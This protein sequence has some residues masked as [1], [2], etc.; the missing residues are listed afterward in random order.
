VYFGTSRSANRIAVDTDSGGSSPG[1][2]SRVFSTSAKDTSH[3][4]I[5]PSVVAPYR[6]DPSPIVETGVELKSTI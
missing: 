5:C 2:H 4:I 6:Y 3:Q 1:S